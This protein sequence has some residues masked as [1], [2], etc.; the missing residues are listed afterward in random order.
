FSNI[1]FTTAYTLTVTNKAGKT[2][3][4]FVAAR[5]SARIDS[6]SVGAALSTS[7]T[8][9]TISSGTTT[10]LFAAFGGSGSSG[11]APAN[12]SCLKT[13]PPAS[14]NGTLAATSIAGGG[15]VTVTGNVNGTLTYTLTV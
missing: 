7:S 1:Q 5:V 11:N 13:A 4:A 8:T 3:T 10:N 14:C 9:A 12:L 6:F 2:A 15:S